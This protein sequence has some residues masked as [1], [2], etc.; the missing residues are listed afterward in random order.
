MLGNIF[1]LFHPII[2]VDPTQGFDVVLYLY[3]KRIDRTYAMHLL[4]TA[5]VTA[6][7]RGGVRPS[8]A[9]PCSK[10]SREPKELK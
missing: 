8:N 3:N 6:H 2:K 1:S 9:S 4:Q 10:G 7:C 5:G